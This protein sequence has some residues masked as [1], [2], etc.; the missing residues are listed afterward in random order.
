MGRSQRHKVLEQN[1]TSRGEIF[2]EGAMA[3][4]VLKQFPGPPFPTVPVGPP[5][6]PLKGSSMTGAIP[7]TLLA[8]V[9]HSGTSDPL[10]LPA[11]SQ[12]A[13]GT[14]GE[15][16]FP[17]GPLTLLRIEPS[18]DPL[19]AWYVVDAT[20]QIQEDDDVTIEATGSSLTNGNY[21]AT[22]V[23][24]EGAET[25]FFVPDV[26]LASQIDAKGRVTI[27]DGAL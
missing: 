11:P 7:P 14:E 20:N 16:Q 21:T 4:A 1:T 17:I 18:E 26:V 25:R 12:P 24:T 5:G 27:T 9:P 3:P 23:S 22:E 6:G 13:P 15:R 19:G 2:A 8:P 10:Q